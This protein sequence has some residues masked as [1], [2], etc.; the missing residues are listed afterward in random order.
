[1]S[2]DSSCCSSLGKEYSVTNLSLWKVRPWMLLYWR[3]LEETEAVELS[4]RRCQ[5]GLNTTITTS[6][7]ICFQCWVSV[8]QNILSSK[9]ASSTGRKI[10]QTLT[11]SLS[12]AGTSSACA[13]GVEVGPEEG[14]DSPVGD[15]ALGDDMRNYGQAILV[16]L[17][18]DEREWYFVDNSI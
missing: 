3:I 7:R 14:D 6:L 18:L 9:L 11:S 17:G 16:W 1:M 5:H 8:V 4:L 10:F 13:N 12:I 15:L 2:T